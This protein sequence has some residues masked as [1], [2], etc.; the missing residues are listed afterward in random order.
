MKKGNVKGSGRVGLNRRG[1]LGLSALAGA[2]AALNLL[3][4]ASAAPAASLP[5]QPAG[6]KKGPGW[7]VSDD[8][9]IAEL[10]AMM[11]A[12]ESPARLA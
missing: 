8:P 2:G 12:G 3:G 9:S 1:F 6:D 11:A 5:E 10:Q 7:N 4:Q